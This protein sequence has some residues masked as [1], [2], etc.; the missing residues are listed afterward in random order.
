MAF[1]L[2]S[3]LKYIRYTRRVVSCLYTYVTVT[4]SHLPFKTKIKTNYI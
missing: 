2:I 3:T 1:T 4:N